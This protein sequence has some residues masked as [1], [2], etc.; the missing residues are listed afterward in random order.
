MMAQAQ[1]NS[2]KSLA[3]LQDPNILGYFP[4]KNFF[5]RSAIKVY[6]KGE[7]LSDPEDSAAPDA[8]MFYR[9]SIIYLNKKKEN[10][11]KWELES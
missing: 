7:T 8:I 4:F 3:I 1:I 9:I 5:K 6:L 2:K 11:K 10:E